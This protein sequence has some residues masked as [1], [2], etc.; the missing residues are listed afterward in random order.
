MFPG[1]AESPMYLRLTQ[2][3][4]FAQKQYVHV[5]ISIRGEVLIY[6]YLSKGDTKSINRAEIGNKSVL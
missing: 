6:F 2:I 1:S 3:H 4:V 5:I